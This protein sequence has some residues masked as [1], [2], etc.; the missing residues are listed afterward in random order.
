M[1][2]LLLNSNGSLLAN[3]DGTLAYGEPG[4]ECC[5]EG[6]LNCTELPASI[7]IHFGTWTNGGAWQGNS[8]ELQPS[9]TP[10]CYS[11]NEGLPCG[12]TLLTA[13]IVKNQLPPPIGTFQ[14]EFTAT[15]PGGMYEKLEYTV[16]IDP[17]IYTNCKANA[18]AP[19]GPDT[20]GY[21]G[22]GSGIPTCTWSVLAAL[23]IF[24]DQVQMTST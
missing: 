18:N 11:L 6:C 17:P 16:D 4:G 9:G 10:C 3:P 20:L 14:V 7:T 24:K 23:Q 15:Y 22:P 8:Y 1:P 12:C 2:S 19:A 21:N 13:C 5:C